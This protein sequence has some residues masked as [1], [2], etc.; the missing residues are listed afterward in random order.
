MT[1]IFNS[2]GRMFEGFSNGSM[3]GKIGIAIGSFLTALYAPIA[4]LLISCFAFTVTDMI[5]GIKVAISKNS[6]ILS[7]KTWKGTLSKLL[8]EFS[9]LSLARLLEYSVMGTSGVF[10]LTGGTT[11]IFCLTELWSILENLNTL[12]PN[13]PWKALGKFLKKKGEEHIGFEIDLDDGNDC[14]DNSAS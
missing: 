14:V 5:Y 2:V 7:K 10:V 13:G 8:E 12:N 1:G 6:K 11:I 3:L 9:I 4:L